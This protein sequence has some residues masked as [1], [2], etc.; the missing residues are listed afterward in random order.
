MCNLTNIRKGDV[1]LTQ[2]DTLLSGCRVLDLTDEKGH[3]AGKVLGDF[4]ADVV[5]IEKPGGDSSR[6]VG[7]FYK[8]MADPE[9]SLF[10]FAGNTSKRGITLDIEKP[11]GREIFKKLVETA[12]IVLES[13][14]PG[15]M[16]GMGLGYLELKKIKLDIIVTSITPFGQSGPY[17]HYQTT[18]LVA[19]AMGGLARVLGDMG[20]P[21][22]RMSCDP[23]AYFHAGLQGALGSM[24][25]YYH[26]ALSGEGQH[27]DVS[28][29]DAVILALMHAVE[30][31]EIMKV[32]VIGMG[33][34]FVS[35]RPAPQPPL[36]TRLIV[37]CKDGYVFFGF[38]GGGFGG[39]VQSTRA[40]VEWANEE[41]MLLEFKDVDFS[42]WDVSSMT[43]EESDRRNAVVGEFLMTKTKAELYDQAVKRGIMLAPCNTI[44]DVIENAQLEVRGFWEK[45]EHPELGET[46]TYPGAPVKIEEA[47]WRIQRRAP[48]I[49][50]HNEE[51]YIEELGFSREQMSVLEAS[52]VI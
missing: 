38:G 27:V 10:W 32:N 44:E 1:T 24:M 34:F 23:Q 48:F 28:M 50:E 5:K 17:V 45:V 39:M 30:I 46:I 22:V 36:F 19:T 3:L 33:Q 47:P 7:P 9:K 21:P 14:E 13:F 49:S 37:P 29:Q 4:G 43:Q 42:Q 31:S 2:H 16:D 11:E 18:D 20:R 41:G 25:A 40:M 26:R 35:V 8:D 52:G 51:I 12:D 15:Y 6:N